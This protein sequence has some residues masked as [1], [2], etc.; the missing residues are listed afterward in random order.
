MMTLTLT[1]TERI[2]LIELIGKTTIASV[3][4]EDEA[5]ALYTLFKKLQE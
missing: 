5:L 4:T 2:A 1:A 3:P